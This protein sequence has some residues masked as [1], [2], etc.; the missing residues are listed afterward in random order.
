[1]TG[2]VSIGDF[3][4]M[5]HL[6]VKTL[7]HYHD[8]GLLAPAAIDKLNGYRYYAKSQVP[9]AQVIRRFRALDM[10]IDEVRA[11]IKTSDPEERSQ[12]I[13][14]HLA[15]LEQQLAETHAAVASLRAIVERPELPLPIE[16]RAVAQASTIAISERIVVKDVTAWMTAA[17]AE[18]YDALRS[19]GVKT[20]GPSGA[21]WSNELFTDGEGDATVFVPIAALVRAVGRSRALVV[22]AAELAITV[23]DGAHVDIDRTYGALGTYV[24]EHEVGVDDFVREYYLVDQF[25]TADAASWRTEIA[26]PIFRAAK[27]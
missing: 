25:H 12:Q 7:R 20:T 3:S 15:R 4:R 6:S 10:P 1:M 19:Q 13:I 11:I 18:I 16:Q 17:Y 24:A 5:T 14:A 9:L 8:V 21:L 27:H 26:W 22:P 23:H 2:T